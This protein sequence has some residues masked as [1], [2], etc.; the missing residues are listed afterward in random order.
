MKKSYLGE[1]DVIKIARWENKLNRWQWPDD[2]PI[3]KLIGFDKLPN[4]SSNKN[5]KTKFNIINPLIYDIIN[6]IG[7]KETFR[8]WHI[9]SLGS[10]NLKFEIW[11]IFRK[12]NEFFRQLGFKNFY[13]DSYRLFGWRNY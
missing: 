4:Y 3:K 11:W 5:I 9:D 10:N 13:I 12:I 8:W 7:E 1:T 2:F 6:A